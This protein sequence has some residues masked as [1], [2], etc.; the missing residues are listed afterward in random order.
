MLLHGG[1]QHWY[2]WRHIIPELASEF[3]LVCPDL[4]GFGWSDVPAGGYR[5][6]DRAA[7]MIGVLDALGLD[8]MQLAGHD[9][10]AWVG[11]QMCFDACERIERFLAISMAHPWQRLSAFSNDWRLWYQLVLMTPGLGA[12]AQR[13]TGFVRFMLNRGV[14]DPSKAWA[15]GER[16]HYAALVREPDRAGA[17]AR[18]YR[19]LWSLEGAKSLLRRE[20]LNLPILLIHGTRDFAI[21]PRIQRSGWQPHAPN[22][23][24]ELVDGGSHWLLNE[25]PELITARA[26]DF[27]VG[28]G[29]T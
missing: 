13:R 3:R 15:P 29:V 9:W 17:Q 21:G 4:R 2:A 28:R 18:M 16:E 7:D 8:Q 24:V 19:A 14:A 22:M 11:F 5:P 25:R 6:S 12:W 1:P 10:G 20:P 27:F 26:R 23:S